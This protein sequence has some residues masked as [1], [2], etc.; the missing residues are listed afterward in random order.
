MKR[1]RLEADE[2]EADKTTPKRTKSDQWS[3]TRIAHWRVPGG[4]LM[5]TLSPDEEGED[6]EM[7]D[8]LSS[9]PE[10]LFSHENFAQNA[11]A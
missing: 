5:V 6:E 3:P 7:V 4:S 11:I 9:P 10:Q 1:A 8:A 2:P